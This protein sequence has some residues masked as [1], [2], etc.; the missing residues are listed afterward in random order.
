M[1]V[2]DN[3]FLSLRT[4]AD[5]T[6]WLHASCTEWK[7]LFSMEICGRDGKLDIQGLGGSYGVERIAC[8][9]N[10]SGWNRWTR[11]VTRLSGKRCGS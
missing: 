3:A 6:S 7:H 5:Q 11:F 10:W 8:I 4:G 9:R 2:G 1:S